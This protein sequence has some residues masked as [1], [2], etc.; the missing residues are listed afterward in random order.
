MSRKVFDFASIF[1]PV[2]KDFGHI[3][4]CWGKTHPFVGS[5]AETSATYQPATYLKIP[6]GESSNQ[7][8]KQASLFSDG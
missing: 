4:R 2:P 5:R 1:Y 8:Y 6:N 7:L 3:K